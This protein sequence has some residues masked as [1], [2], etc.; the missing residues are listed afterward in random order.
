MQE[1]AA[2]DWDRII[3]K[4]VRTSDLEQIGNIAS[5]DG[6]SIIILGDRSGEYKVPK[7][8]VSEFDGSQVH[9]D[10]PMREM[11]KYIVK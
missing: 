9:L 4:N 1:P 10:L 8:Q 7:S 2:L 11:G 5:E 3:H 6:E